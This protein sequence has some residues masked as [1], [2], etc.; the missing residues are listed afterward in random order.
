MLYLL[1]GNLIN[2]NSLNYLISPYYIAF[3]WYPSFENLF[4]F[5]KLIVKK[6]LSNADNYHLHQLF[7]LFLKSKKF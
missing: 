6:N 2:F 5:K 1:I 7:F 4:S 3:F